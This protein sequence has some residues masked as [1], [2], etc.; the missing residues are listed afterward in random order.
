MAA[1]W[2]VVPCSLVEADGLIVST[3]FVIRALKMKAV[4]ISKTGLSF[5][6]PCGVGAQGDHCTAT[7]YDLLCFL[8]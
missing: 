3:T 4:Q 5:I 1:V 6:Y 7:I 8:I 2:D